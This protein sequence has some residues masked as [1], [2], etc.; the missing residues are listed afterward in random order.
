MLEDSKLPTYL[1]AEAINTTCFTENISIINH[2]QGKTT[3]QLMKNKIPTLG[4]FMS[5][6]ENDLF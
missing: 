3:Y 4:F 1:W 2:A 5:L 6:D